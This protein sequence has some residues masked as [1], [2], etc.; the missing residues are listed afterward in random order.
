MAGFPDQVVDEQLDRSDWKFVSTSGTV[1]RVVT[2]KDFERRDIERAAAIHSLT[3]GTNYR[4]GLR[5]LQI[6]PNI[7]NI[8]CGEGAT[9]EDE[10]FRTELLRWLR[11]SLS[12]KSPDLSDLRGAFERRIVYRTR[13]LSPLAPSGTQLTSERLEMFW[14]RI[15]REKAFLLHALPEYLF[16]LAEWAIAEGRKPLGIPRIIP[17][18]G[19]TTPYMRQRIVEGL[20]GVFTDFY[21]TA[22]LGPVAFECHSNDG[23]RVIMEMFLLE[24]VCNDRPAEPGELGKLLITDLTNHAM[25]FLRY[26]V[27]D[28][29]VWWPA[30]KDSED[31]SPRLRVV[32]RLDEILEGSKGEPVVPEILRDRLFDQADCLSFCVRAREGRRL[33]IDYVPRGQDLGSDHVI[34]AVR[35]L[36]HPSFR[37][38]ARLVGNIPAEPSGK[39]RF[40]RSQSNG[41]DL[42]DV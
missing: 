9:N 15:R 14:N 39:F 33:Q 21:G 7:C 37:I 42:L 19:N 24:V 1:A 10:S 12:R 27:G 18:G 20:G 25:P 36:L 23:L 32:G 17:M 26:Q 11:G 34:D 6:P 4:P 31:Q 3:C 40:I 5:F 35:P 38:K 16:L 29:A 13:I 41:V 2:V 8:V 22:E 28:A 30:P